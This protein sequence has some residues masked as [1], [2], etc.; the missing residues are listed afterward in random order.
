M[1]SPGIPS[2]QQFYAQGYAVI[3]TPEEEPDSVVGNDIENSFKGKSIGPTDP[4]TPFNALTFL[5]TIA[6]Y[7]TESRTLGWIANDPTENKYTR[8]IDSAKANLSSS[9]ARRGTAK[10]KLDS[11][12]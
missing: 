6:S 2:I 8:L 4:P 5:D 1:T 11:V 9:P 7:I 12:L 3:P 10:A